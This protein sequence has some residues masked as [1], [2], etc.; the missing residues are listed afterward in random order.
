MKS[1]LLSVCFAMLANFGFTQNIPT[2]P[3]VGKWKVISFDAGIH[4]DYKSGKTTFPEKLLAD[5]KGKKDS[6]I[7]VNLLKA[8]ATN[9]ENYH[10]VFTADGKFQEIRETKIKQEG[11][12]KVDAVKNLIETVTISKL[13]TPVKQT[14]SYLIKGNNIAFMVPQRDKK[15]ELLVEKVVE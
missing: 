6:S 4:H 7:T 9:Y 11:T 3:V 12:Y 13:G 2:S 15:A 5:L 1:I 14:F 8:F 10:F